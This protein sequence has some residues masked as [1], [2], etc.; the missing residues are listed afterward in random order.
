MPNNVS[1]CKTAGTVQGALSF[2]PEIDC[3][4]TAERC[5]VQYI[6]LYVKN[7]VGEGHLYRRIGELD[8][9]WIA[10]EIQN[11]LHLANCCFR[12]FS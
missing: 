12:S 3:A 9:G 2:T 8:I 1:I 10:R 4:Q 5:N 6:I 11:Q 7:L